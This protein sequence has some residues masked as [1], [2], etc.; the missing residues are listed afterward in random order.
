MV[1]DSPH[2]V[3]TPPTVPTHP[4]VSTHSKIDLMAE[5]FLNYQP[6]KPLSYKRN[7]TKQQSDK[8]II[9]KHNLLRTQ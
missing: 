3:P 9:L 4:S 5:F 6:F 7:F 2:S 1:S 8:P